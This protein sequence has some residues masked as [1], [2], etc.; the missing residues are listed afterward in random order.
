MAEEIQEAVQIIRVAYDGI[1][2]AMKVGSGGIA[3]MQ[4][5]LEVLTGLLDY[6]KS[7]GRTSMRKLLLKGGDLQVFQFQT[8]DMKQV[9]KM[10]KKYGILYS[11]LPNCNR[12]DGMSEIIFH[13]EAV[14]RVNMMIQKLKFG[15]IATFDDYL[16]NG[17]EKQLGKL[18]DFL[19]K[20][21][22]N[23][24]SHTVEDS[25]VN[26]AIDG[27]IEK[28][29]MFAMEKKAISVDQIKEN[30]SINGEQAETVIKQLE[31][32]GVL[33][34]KS[35]DGMHKVVMD[36]EA[37]INRVRGYQDLAE[38]MRAIA[39]SKNTNLSD[40]T[41]SKKLIAAEN[42]HAVKTRI[43]GTWGENAN[44]VWLRKENI[45]D[46]HNGKTMLT[47]LDNEKDYK[48]YDEENR[49]VKTQKGSELY[50]HYDKVEASVRERYEQIQKMD[51]VQKKPIIQTQP[52]T[53]KAR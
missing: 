38:R 44:Y 2:I 30:F 9:Q 19:R 24:K 11:V 3:A 45:M 28:V 20:Q 4:K 52:S 41:I 23:E 46:I 26:A 53:K 34:S 35:E 6:E 17:D 39:A 49:V 51:K 16:K 13:T 14:P 7:L 48:I 29:G 50:S 33:G 21:Q 10:A 1:E 5:A 42:D 12:A 40:V 22:G 47:F 36:K 32:I 8:E 15:K 18:M 43:P 27:L 37:F 31:T 25:R